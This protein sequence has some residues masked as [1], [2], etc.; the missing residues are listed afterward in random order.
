MGQG[1]GEGARGSR[2]LSAPNSAMRAALHSAM[3]ISCLLRSPG[4][5]YG[6]GVSTPVAGFFFEDGR[7]SLDTDPRI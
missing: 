2:T 6:V 3:V 4:V 7:S 5:W 1:L